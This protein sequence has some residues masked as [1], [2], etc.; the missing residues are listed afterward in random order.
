LSLIDATRYGV[1][2]ILAPGV[3]RC[4]RDYLSRRIVR[5]DL[6]PNIEVTQKQMDDKPSAPIIGERYQVLCEIGQG[7][8]GKVLKARHLQLNKLVAIKVL[9]RS[10][11]G[12]GNARARFELEATSGS[13]LSHP[14]LV[15]VFDYGFTKEDEPYIVM[16]YVEGESLAQRIQRRGPL[17]V[18]ESLHIFQQIARALEYMH[19][20][21]VIHRDLK[22]GNIMLQTIGDEVHAR[23]VDFGIAKV[24]TEGGQPATNLTETGAVCGGP[25]YMSPEQCMGQKIDN[26]SDIYSLGCVMYECLSG[27]P[28]LSG[29]NALQTVFR[30]IN[31]KPPSLVA[32]VGDGVAGIIEKCMEKDPA[33]RFQSSGEL[34]AALKL[35][36]SHDIGHKAWLAP[37]SKPSSAHSFM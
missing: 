4:S 7:G 12:D 30:Q 33:R 5:E 28:P 3:E 21:H 14:N 18:P 24:L 1:S 23:V 31:E 34:L 6:A 25:N 35:V 37:G 27:A 36:A 22:P 11:V 13:Q 9:D 10:S 15:Q 19:S 26:R 17:D 20:K 2:F 29:E 32:T 8:M 16:E